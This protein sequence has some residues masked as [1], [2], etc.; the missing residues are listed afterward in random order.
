MLTVSFKSYLFSWHLCIKSN[1][2]IRTLE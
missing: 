1:I 2:S